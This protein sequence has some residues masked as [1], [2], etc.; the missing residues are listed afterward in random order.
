MAA[1][2]LSQSHQVFQIN[3]IKHHGASAWARRS[4]L[5]SS[6]DRAAAPGLFAEARSCEQAL[7]PDQGAHMHMA[8]CPSALGTCCFLQLQGYTPWMQTNTPGIGRKIPLQLHQPA[9][10]S[11]ILSSQKQGWHVRRTSLMNVVQFRLRLKGHKQRKGC[12]QHPL[13]LGDLIPYKDLVGCS[14]LSILFL[15]HT[16]ENKLAI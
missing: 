13:C 12:G 10:L 1:L 6:V 9:T 7:C 11:Y 3:F 15:F 5:A 8:L 14:D 16:S 4:A 2:K